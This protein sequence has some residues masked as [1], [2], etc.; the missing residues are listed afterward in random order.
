MRVLIACEMSG[1]VRD[2][3]K[4]KGHDAWSCDLLPTRFAGNHYQQDVLPLLDKNWDLLIAF[5]PC[6]RI[7]NAGNRHKYLVKN[8]REKKEAIKFVDQL[9]NAPI[10]YI[11]IENP[12]GS[13]STEWQK[14]TQ[15]IHPYQFGH[16]EEKKTCLWLKN[17]PKLESTNNVQLEMMLTKTKK[18]RQKIQYEYCNLPPN[19]RAIYR[20]FTFKG[21]AQAM[22]AQW[23]NL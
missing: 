14:P 20:S 8:Q 4:A 17:L 21:I 15:I 2:A 23:S 5:P 18:Q 22:A 6:T 16:L 7:T 11:A 19:L 13:L 9:W 10:P 3:F 1:R 12:I